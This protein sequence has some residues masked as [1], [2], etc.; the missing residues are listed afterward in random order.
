M[1]TC[2]ASD[3]KSS[4]PA[5]TLLTEIFLKCGNRSVTVC[6]LLYNAVILASAHRAVWSASHI[7]LPPI[8]T[9][10]LSNCLN[11]KGRPSAPSTGFTKGAT[12]CV[13]ISINP[14]VV[15]GVFSPNCA[16]NSLPQ[17]PAA[18]TTL[19]QGKAPLLVFTT[20]SEPCCL[21]LVAM[22]LSS[23]KPPSARV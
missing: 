19:A 23:T 5:Q 6:A 17:A 21:M 16:A 3:I 1:K 13:T 4:T 18:L 2:I 7:R 12:L 8:N 15:A 9:V 11:D 20:Q 10:P 14:L 22:E